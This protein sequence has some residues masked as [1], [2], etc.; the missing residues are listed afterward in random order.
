[1]TDLFAKPTDTHQFLNQ[2]FWHPHH[3]KKEILYIQALEF[4]Q[5]TRTLIDVDDL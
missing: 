5:I 4:V 3:C 2:T 1:M